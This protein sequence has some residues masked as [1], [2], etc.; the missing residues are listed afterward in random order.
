M[1]VREVRFIMPNHARDVDKL[2]LRI[3]ESG[4]VIIE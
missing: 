2:V 1:A 3:G 4:V